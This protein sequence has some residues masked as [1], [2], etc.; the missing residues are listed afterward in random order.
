MKHLKLFKTQVEFDTAT[1]ELP[2]IS[3]IEES[4]KVN[5]VSKT[6]D[7]FNGHEYVD[8]GLPSGTLWA[9]CNIG[10]EKESDYGLYFAWGETVGYKDASSGKSFSWSDYKYCNGSYDTLTKYNTS[11]SYGTVDNLTA[12]EPSD[13][14]ASVIL[15]GSWRMPS[16]EEY[17]ELFNNTT[18]TWTTVNEVNGRLFTGNNGN[19]LFLPASGYCRDGNVYGVGSYGIYWSSSLDPSGSPTLARGMGI[20]SNTCSSSG[21]SRFFGC[22]VRGVIG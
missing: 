21:N 1:L 14:A 10:A 3:F 17:Q 22:S 11:S 13:N 12:L 16:R 8:L 6:S 19:T 15:G 2:N 4:N 5:F 9:K 20:Y 7:P 18:N